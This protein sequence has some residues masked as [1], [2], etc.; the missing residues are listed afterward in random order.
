MKSKRYTVIS[1][2]TAS[3]VF[4]LAL[5]PSVLVAKTS[6][7]FTDLKDLDDATKA[8]F[9]AMIKAGIFDG[10]SD[11]S[12]GVNEE[13]NRAQFAKVAALVMGLDVDKDL[14]TS[15]FSDVKADSTGGYALPYIEALKE[16]G[17]TDGYGDGT[18]DPAGK[19]TK[20]QLATFLVRIIGKD[21]EAKLA[22]TSSDKTDTTVSSWAT[23]YVN[24]ALELKLLDKKTD[25]TF[26]GKEDAKRDLLVTG[27]F[28]TAKNLELERGVEVSGADFVK[29]NK[30]NLTLSVNIDIDS[31]DLA[32]IM[33]NGIALDPKLDSFELSED[34]KTIIIKLHDGFRLDTSK[35]PV[36]TVKGLTSVYGNKV[37]S[38]ESKPIPVEVT[39]A[40]VVPTSTPTPVTAPEPTPAPS[41]QTEPNTDNTNQPNPNGP[42][43]P[44]GPN[45]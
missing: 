28:E 31:I 43:G 19:V 20:E 5:F 3:L 17:I 35:T 36:I 45:Q 4:L 7:D 1:I 38:D 11:N 21:D 44:N 16:S 39:E 6:T 33:I 23:G 24:L 25:G 29:G 8:K 27:S 26:G 13:M 22:S 14:K 9:D 42:S 12:F 18:F 10:T 32:N 40:P 15:S 30:L 34:K 2:I 41:Q 37:E